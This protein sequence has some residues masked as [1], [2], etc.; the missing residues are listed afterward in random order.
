MQLLDTYL[1]LLDVVC[2]ILTS[3]DQNINHLIVIILTQFKISM[4]NINIYCLK[5]NNLDLNFKIYIMV[6]W[7]DVI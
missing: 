6:I 3:N 1:P 7:Q 5:I 2:K 4:L